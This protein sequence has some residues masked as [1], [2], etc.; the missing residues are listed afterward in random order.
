MTDGL[1]CTGCTAC[2]TG[3]LILL[4][5]AETGFKTQEIGGDSYVA[6]DAAGNCVYLQEG[7]GCLVHDAKPLRCANFDCRWYLALDAEQISKS[8][9]NMN[10]P[11]VLE[12]ARR[13]RTG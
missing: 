7:V 3:V 10:F 6:H 2:C 12:A 5:P 1:D 8:K 9:S 13:Q 4:D 11:A